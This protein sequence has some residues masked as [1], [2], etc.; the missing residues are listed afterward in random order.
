VGGNKLHT[1]RDFLNDYSTVSRYNIITEVFVNKLITAML[2]FSIFVLVLP[3]VI[4]C[5]SN[6]LVLPGQTTP[7]S[8][9]LLDA[10]NEIEN[11]SGKQIIVRDMTKSPN[12]T[13]NKQQYVLGQI[14]PDENS[15]TVWL[16]PN[17]PSSVRE[18]IAA[19]ELGHANQMI[20]GWCKITILA[21]PDGTPISQELMLIAN[22]ITN[23]IQD[24]NADY[25]ASVHGFNIDEYFNSYE[26]K[27][28][29]SQDLDSL[30]SLSQEAHDWGNLQSSLDKVASDISNHVKIYRPIKLS[31]LELNTIA[32]ALFFAKVKLEY[33]TIESF[34]QVDEL[35]KQKLP[36]ARNLG[37]ELVDIVKDIG[38]S[39][40]SQNDQALVKILEY[41]KLPLNLFVIRN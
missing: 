38:Y 14:D 39:S 25:W 19:H 32:F 17:V 26:I 7:A 30:Y 15:F 34:S 13:N 11:K 12:Y 40:K 35:Y 1:L 31:N 20:E 37:I 8:K 23:M 16:D 5:N 6:V 36:I 28:L 24:V 33:D 21:F 2:L 3:Y 22:K 41:L 10:I 29:L 18:V 27:E 4:G 9:T